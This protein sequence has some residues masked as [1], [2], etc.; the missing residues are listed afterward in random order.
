MAVPPRRALRKRRQPYRLY[1]PP[2]LAGWARRLGRSFCAAALGGYEAVLEPPRMVKD[3]C[4]WLNNCLV[5]D[6]HRLRCLNTAVEESA[7]V[8]R[9]RARRRANNPHIWAPR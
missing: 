8:Q 4:Y 2:V 5:R 9:E 1:P 6:G 3:V 7:L